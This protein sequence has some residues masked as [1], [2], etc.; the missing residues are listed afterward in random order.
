MIP[1][2]LTLLG[3]TVSV[4]NPVDGKRGGEYGEPFEVSPVRF[5]PSKQLQA[6]EYVM[7]EDHPS[8]RLFVDAVNSSGALADGAF[9]VKVG[10]L[11]S[12][13]GSEWATVRSV[14]EY[15]AFGNDIHHWE[16]EVA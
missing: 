7:V 10:A 3:S 2:P 15:R 13:D 16:C 5:E 11:V 14:N 9:A 6:G 1:I 4:R 8:G 12:I